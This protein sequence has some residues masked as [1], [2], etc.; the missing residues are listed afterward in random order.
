MITSAANAWTAW[1]RDWGL[2]E[3]TQRNWLQRLFRVAGERNGLLFRAGWGIDEYPGLTVCVRFP[4]T[5]DT[6]GLQQR[7]I[8]DAT[9]DGLPGKGGARRRMVVRA[10]APRTTFRWG[11]PPE[12]VLT[13]TS[14]TWRRVFSWGTPKPAR[15]Q[16]WVEALVAAVARATPVFHGRCESCNVNAVPRHVLVDG[17]PSLLCTGCQ[18]RTLAEGEMAERAYEMTDANHGVGA[19]LAGLAALVGAVG[20]AA[21][22]A[23][24]QREFAAAAIGIGALIAWAYRRGAGRVDAAGRVVGAALTLAS[25]TLGDI[26]LFAGWVARARPD[27][28]FNLEAGWSVYL[29]AWQKRPADQ[30]ITILLAAAGAWVAFQVLAAPKLTHTIQ[31]ADEVATKRAA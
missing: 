30:V 4:R 15:I 28:G 13:E 29:S 1:A 24:T 21:V 12:F 2:T 9:L 26:L 6:A 23:L 16:A 7:L 22:S 14:L 5:V 19:V 8:D 20:W 17:V 11:K 25:V 3:Q 18:Q 10:D 27:I 31:Q